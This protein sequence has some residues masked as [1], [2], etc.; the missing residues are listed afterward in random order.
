MVVGVVGVGSWLYEVSRR[1]LKSRVGRVDEW[2][3][4]VF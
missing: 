3:M 4:W 2:D 1:V